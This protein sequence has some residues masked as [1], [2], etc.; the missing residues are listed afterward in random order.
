M[1]DMLINMA[2]DDILAINVN[3]AFS[4]WAKKYGIC[5]DHDKHWKCGKQPGPENEIVFNVNVPF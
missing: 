2:N 4:I 5:R 3:T 1:H